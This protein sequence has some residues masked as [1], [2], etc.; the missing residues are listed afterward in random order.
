MSLN[1]SVRERQT[2]E[3]VTASIAESAQARDGSSE[4]PS[5]EFEPEDVK[6]REEAPTTYYEEV[7][8]LPG[9]G[10]APNRCRPMQ[11][12]G[13]CEHGHPILGRSSCGVRYCPDHWRDW[14]EEAVVNMVAR[15][16]AYR[17]V[18]E[19]KAK[20]LLH[21]VASPDQSKRYGVRGLF[22]TRT[23]AYDAFEAAGVRG[24]AV[25]THPYRTNE[26]GDALFESALSAGVVE[27]DT[28]RWEFLRD[29]AGDDWDELTEYV[30]ASPHYHSLA[31][32]EDV[33]GGDAPGDWVVE[34]IRSMK[35]FHYKDMEAYRD[36][37]ATAYYV[38]THG[39]VMDGRATVTYFGDVHPVA[40][41]PEE[42]LTSYR[43]DVI[44][45]MAEEAVKGTAEEEEGGI[46]GGPSECPREACEAAVV[47]LMYLPEYLDDDDFVSAVLSHRDGRARLAQLRGMVAWWES[48][49]DRPPPHAQKSE[50]RLLE[51]LEE[52]GEAFMPEPS[53][54]SLFD[55]RVMG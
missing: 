9:F 45:S 1:Q 52:R 47:D 41:D 22:E 39:A 17:E 54:V 2:K 49:T 38:L 35:P 5:F 42:E 26:R 25:V 8:R 18:M 32:A 6:L 27:E 51:W 33:D 7:V 44:Q 28:G 12:V 43:W 36:M 40:F 19:G 21:L 24:G 3:S 29:V 13:F 37:V 55:A 11:P 15:L 4:P 31:A 23:D 20:R 34:N 10:D 46:S 48:R 50:R 53:Q 30:E 14:C 16:A